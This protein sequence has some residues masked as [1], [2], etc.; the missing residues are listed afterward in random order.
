MN[1]FVKE[2]TGRVGD[3]VARIRNRLFA[4]GKRVPVLL[5][6]RVADEASQ[7]MERYTVA[8]SDFESH[9]RFLRKARFRAMSLAQWAHRISA[10]R[11]APA[12]SVVITFDDGYANFQTAWTLL[13]KWGLGATLFV[14]TAKVG[15]P[16]PE[17]FLDWDDLRVLAGQGLEIG[18]HTVTHRSLVGLSEIDRQ[19]EYIGSRADL[20]RLLG[21]RV[22]GFSYP[23]GEF[24]IACRKA[25]SEAGYAFAVTAGWCGT[26]SFED[27]AEFRSSTGMDDVM[28]IP[29]LEVRGD[30]SLEA[31]GAAV[32]DGVTPWR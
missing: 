10:G 3:R 32:M 9:L 19:D 30:M 15:A 2:R 4:V 25:A 17:P 12:R 29:R 8:P 18:S 14:V 13:R 23:Y 7:G 22:Q 20:E 11:P 1:S 28:A 6:H 31:F 5:Y 24:D 16:Q 21:I 26:A 27:G